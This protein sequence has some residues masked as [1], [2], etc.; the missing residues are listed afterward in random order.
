MH[1]HTHNIETV[2][3]I[4]TENAHMKHK[5]QKQRKPIIVWTCPYNCAHLRL[6]AVLTIFPVILQRE[7]TSCQQLC[8]TQLY[9]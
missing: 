9:Q 8:F 3:L 5:T 2:S 1:T 4:F 6:M 7:H